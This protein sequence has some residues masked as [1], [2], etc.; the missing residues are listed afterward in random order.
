[1]Y[2]L[3]IFEFLGTQEAMLIL[4]AA[5]ILFG[6]RKLPQLARSLGKSLTE[7]KR[8]SEDF[9][10]QWENEVERETAD[11]REGVKSL[12]NELA[13]ATWNNI[14]AAA[15]TNNDWLPPAPASATQ[16]A[17]SST[18][19]MPTAATSTITPTVVEPLPVRP[20]PVAAVPRKQDWL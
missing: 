20:A 2:F 15:E 3:L 6:P 5:L 14:A 16:T 1:M 13:P 4:V 19:T 10:Q 17:P 18:N 11:V 7:F 9:K 12:S 8:A